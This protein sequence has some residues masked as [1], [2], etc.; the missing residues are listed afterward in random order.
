MSTYI[1][2]MPAHRRDDLTRSQ[3]RAQLAEMRPA[4]LVLPSA[5]LGEASR[6]VLKAALRLP[7]TCRYS[8]AESSTEIIGMLEERGYF[9]QWPEVLK[10][11]LSPSTCSS[12]QKLLLAS[13]QDRLPVLS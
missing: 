12:T 9:A 4:E 6:K 13:S 10:V 1:I 5:P 3:L 2:G 8:A 7:R 11:G